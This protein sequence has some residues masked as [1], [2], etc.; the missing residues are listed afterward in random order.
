[1][2]LLSDVRIGVVFH[3]CGHVV[4]EVV[5]CGCFLPVC[6]QCTVS[7]VGSLVF[8]ISSWDLFLVVNRI[9]GVVVSFSCEGGWACVEEECSLLFKLG[10]LWFGLA[11][12]PR[13]VV[14]GPRCGC[15]L[16]VAG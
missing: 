10:E 4:W 14:W 3:R 6:R 12:R 5:L 9:T 2:W 1:M 16:S 7:V 15:D 13:D 11:L 8:N